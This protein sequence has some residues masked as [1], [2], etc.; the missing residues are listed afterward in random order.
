MNKTLT[1]TGELVVTSCWCG[2]RLAIPDSLYRVAK[3]SKHDIYC[4]VGH[5]FIYTGSENDELKQKVA[6]LEATARMLRTSREA[7]RDQAAAAERSARAYKGHLTRAR[8]KIAAGNCP[9]P[10]CGQH[11]SNVREHMKFK[12]PDYHLTD[13]T[14][15][16]LAVL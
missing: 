9:V 11:F 6:N 15:G 8:N 3:Q 14:T 7:A 16:E 4:P 13:P 1:F 10:D 2:I 5:V 12:H